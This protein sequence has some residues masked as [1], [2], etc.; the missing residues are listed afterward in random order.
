MDLTPAEIALP[1]RQSDGRYR[2][3]KKSSQRWVPELY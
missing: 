1:A 3:P 2:R